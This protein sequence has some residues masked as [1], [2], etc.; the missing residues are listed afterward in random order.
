MA[1]DESVREALLERIEELART[2]KYPANILALAEAWA[3]L[4]RP[5]AAHGGQISIDVKK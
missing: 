5:D 2:T 1:S 3:F 4:V